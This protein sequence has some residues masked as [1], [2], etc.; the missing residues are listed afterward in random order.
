[1]NRGRTEIFTAPADKICR[2]RKHLEDIMYVN[3][4]PAMALGKGRLLFV[5]AGLMQTRRT[6]RRLHL[7]FLV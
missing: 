2:C 4:R 1:M 3:F 5:E 7:M 6:P